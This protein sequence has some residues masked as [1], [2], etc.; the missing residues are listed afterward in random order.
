MKADLTRNTFHPLKHFTRVLMQQGRVQLDSDWNEQAAILLRYLQTLGADLI[1]PAGG[2]DDHAFAISALD[3]VTG[4]FRIGLGRYYVNG[5]PCEAEAEVIPISSPN[6]TNDLVVPQ[7]TLDGKALDQDQVVEIFDNVPQPFATPGITPTLAII[8]TATFSGRKLTISPVSPIALTK[9]VN[10][11]MRRVVTYLT[12]PNLPEPD[13]LGQTSGNNS[14]YLAYL[15][16]WERHITWIEDSSIQE[17]ALGG[18]DTATRAQIVWQVKVTKG[19][20]AD[21]KTPCDQ[22]KPDDKNLLSTLFAPYRGRLR[23]RAMQKS[24]PVDPCLI[25]PDA[26]YNGEENQL[27]RVEVHRGGEVAT[28]GILVRNTTDRIGVVRTGKAAPAD[29]P[30][31]KW[32][33]ENGSVTFPIV[34]ISPGDNVTTLTLANLG[35]D[36]RF[37]LTEQDWVEIQDDDYVLRNQAGTLLQV[38]SIN[39][40]RLQVTLAGKADAIVG[41][42]P[43]KHPLLRR[44]DQEQG[45]PA[46]GGLTLGSD[47][48]ALIQ[49]SDGNLWLELEKGVQVQFQPAPAGQQNEYR[50]GDYWLIPARTA[51]A[52]VEWPNE[53]FTDNQGNTTVT[54]LSKPPDGIQ[55]Y[56]APLGAFTVGNNNSLKVI[57]DSNNT[58]RKHFTI[59]TNK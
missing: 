41:N 9:A 6:N 51:T 53:T 40:S 15:D 47:N 5:M 50:T 12:Q 24:T 58:C 46:E 3:Q 32:S 7:W 43:A 2:P 21:Q 52:D 35:R 44:W 25:A 38:Q 20:M 17:V 14:G 10:P 30:T 59:L 27:Y 42:D 55:H 39:R 37:G 23:A 56:Y 8:K 36:D 48:A 57:S 31:F 1:G 33:R 13:A 54:P 11:C 18:P 4:D 28:S 19:T 34:A 26:N 29:G 22:F 45:D 49:E 16:V